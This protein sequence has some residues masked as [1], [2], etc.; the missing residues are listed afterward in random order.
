MTS[1]I[2]GR[3]HVGPGACGGSRRREGT[4]L[5]QGKLVG[6]Q[7]EPERFGGLLTHTTPWQCFL[8]MSS[9]LCLSLYLTATPYSGRV[10]FGVP[11]WLATKTH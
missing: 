4:D 7:V 10:L 6:S 8:E 9:E 5:V 3:K 1:P 11:G 2:R